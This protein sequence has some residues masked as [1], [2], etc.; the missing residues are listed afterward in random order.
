MSRTLFNA[1]FYTH[2]GFDIDP[3]KP[4][5]EWLGKLFADAAMKLEEKQPLPGVPPEIAHHTPFA[6]AGVLIALSVIGIIA[7][8]QYYKKPPPTMAIDED[9]A[10]FNYCRSKAERGDAAAQYELAQRYTKGKGTP[11]SSEDARTWLER[12]AASGHEKAKQELANG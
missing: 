1:I 4:V 3:L 10:D 11:A 9:R 12:A 8:R 7:A 5:V 2:G 6:I